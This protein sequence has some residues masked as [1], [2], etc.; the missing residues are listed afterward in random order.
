MG[1]KPK[2]KLSKQSFPVLETL[3]TLY[4]NAYQEFPMFKFVT[5]LSRITVPQNMQKLQSTETT[6]LENWNKN[7]KDE[8]KQEITN[9]N[10][11]SLPHI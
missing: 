5:P 10:C 9:I 3:A 8:K 2:G 4:S 7:P 1:K 11:A 6:K